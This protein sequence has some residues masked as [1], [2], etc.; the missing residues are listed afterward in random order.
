[1][2]VAVIC[3][4]MFIYNEL[5]N[6]LKFYTDKYWFS[7]K[8]KNGW[9]DGKIPF[10]KKGKCP[11]GLVPRIIEY[12]KKANYTYSIDF[13]LERELNEDKLLEFVED[14]PKPFP[15]RDFQ[16]EGF[17][18]ALKKRN[19]TIISKT[20][21]GKS[22]IIYLL[23]CY[24]RK[25]NKKMLLVVSKLGLI[26]QMYNDLKKYG[27]TDMDTGVKC[28]YSGIEKTFDEFL[29]IS[30][31]QSIY[32][33]P[34]DQ[35]NVF[36]CVI[37]DEAHEADGKSISG[38]LSKLT[39]A[40]YRI[41]TTGTIVKDN[42]ADYYTVVAYLGEPVIYRTYIELKEQNI[43]SPLLVKIRFLNY[44]DKERLFACENFNKDYHAEIN[45]IEGNEIRNNYI[46]NLIKN[47]C[48]KNT[49]VLFQH[50]EKH[51]KV[52]L[53]LFKRVLKDKKIIYI[54]G[55]VSR[56]D[57]EIARSII[58]ENDNVVILAS[59]GTFSIGID[60]PNIH[61]IIFASS[62]KSFVRTAQSIGRGLRLHQNKD[63][64]I[65]H[66]IVD[67][68]SY[69]ERYYE[70]Y[71]MDHYKSRVKLYTEEEFPMEKIDINL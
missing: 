26:T 11:I 13:T 4:T 6:L 21:T 67:N 19:L 64:L 50:I 68:L 42:T 3:D 61:N 23:I 71:L 8:F 58:A 45:Y 40:E 17:F 36:D 53:D 1:M 33:I 16:I 38:I 52:L 43:L 66:D 62:T 65:V 55:S 9:W 2:E 32:K 51:G 57:R 60:A 69:T 12:I 20:G 54:D 30:T 29:I 18:D 14:L 56:E 70:N 22:F 59:Y 24:M 47:E 46:A 41:G 15:P 63:I 25:V 31:W 10:F 49:L 27:L 37:V 35:I 44:P 5:D 34:E 7:P 48:N 28:I 39:K